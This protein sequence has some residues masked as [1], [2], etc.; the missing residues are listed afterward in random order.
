MALRNV[1]IGVALLFALVE[2]HLYGSLSGGGDADAHRR[3]SSSA[4]INNTQQ[5]CAINLFGLPRA[6]QDLVL[7]SIVQN[8]IVPNLGCDYY[9]HYYHKTE[10]V[11][12]RSGGGGTID[13]TEILRLKD[14]VLQEA[15][16]RGE[17]PLPKVEFMLDTED[18][19][20]EKYATLIEKIRNTK[21]DGKYLYFPWKA[22]TYKHPITTDNIVKM[23][24]SIQSSFQL[25][26]RNA[27]ASNIEYTTVAM[28]RSDVVYVTPIDVRDGGG[29]GVVT[30]PNFGKYPV[31]DRIVYGSAAAVKI[32]ATERFSRL[33]DHVHYVKEKNPGWGMHS[34]RFLDYTIFPAIREEHYNIREHPTLCF[35][36][37][38]ADGSVWISDCKMNSA[39]SVMQALG[40]SMRE[41]V[42]RAIGRACPGEVT[43]LTQTVRSLDCAPRLGASGPKG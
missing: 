36:R 8:V 19:F 13:P 32:W 41:V 37:A 38:R 3:S 11:A 17:T 25:M 23:W 26:E 12:G 43:K 2:F 14:A 7:P 39:P 35:L 42:E 27:A 18:D 34:E 16:R 9:V 33:E 21:I 4:K 24:H 40:G 6:F 22:R 5:R 10:E 31:S 1:V 20:W 30:V 15:Q 28:L 29:T